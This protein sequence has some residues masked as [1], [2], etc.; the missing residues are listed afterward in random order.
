MLHVLLFR[1]LA[2]ASVSALKWSKSNRIVSILVCSHIVGSLCELDSM[3]KSC[4]SGVYHSLTMKGKFWNYWNYI[5]WC[6]SFDSSIHILA[7]IITRFVLI[8]NITCF[9]PFLSVVLIFFCFV[10]LCISCCFY[11]RVFSDFY[12][13]RFRAVAHGILTT[14]IVLCFGCTPS[15]SIHIV[16]AVKGT[17]GRLP[18]N[19]TP[20]VKGDKIILVIWYKD[21]YS[22]PIYR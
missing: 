13:H 6:V 21:G 8:I 22:L 19:I 9:H 20:S 1:I 4:M 16:E 11:S 17:I 12:F 2:L 3:W 5:E 14:A 18:C 15:E 10:L 7:W